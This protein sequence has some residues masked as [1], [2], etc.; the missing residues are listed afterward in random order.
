MHAQYRTPGSPPVFGLRV[1]GQWQADGLQSR[2]P[3]G[4][5]SQSVQIPNVDGLQIRPTTGQVRQPVASLPRGLSGLPQ[6][7][8]VLGGAEAAPA[9]GTAGLGNCKA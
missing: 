5:G 3:C 8:R 6:W 2:P 4:M 1:N 7:W 9:G